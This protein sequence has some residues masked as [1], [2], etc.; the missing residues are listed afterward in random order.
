MSREIKRVPLDFDWPLGEVWG[1]FV[2]PH[3]DG[4]ERCEFCGGS[5]SSS[6][7]LK[8]RNMWYY[9]NELGLP[10]GDWQEKALRVNLT[11][12]DVNFLVDE[13]GLCDLAKQY[14]K[15]EGWVPILNEDGTQY[16]PDAEKVSTIA[17]EHALILMGTDEWILLTHWLEKAGEPLL[18]AACA[19]E[20]RYFPTRKAQKRYEAWTET[21][22][23][24]GDGWQVWEGVSEGSPV[25]PVFE[26]PE[27]L[28]DYLA[29]GGDAWCRRRPDEK[30]PSRRAAIAFVM[31]SGWVPSGAAIPQDDGTVEIRANIHLADR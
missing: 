30:P 22:I 25:S 27:E 24:K 17:R 29:E 6:A 20:G 1:G 13:G 10:V 18:C 23:P 7:L 3:T 14:V 15:G 5:G 11:Q 9:G 16:Y 4:L 12:E 8:L 19:G 28:I 31:S 2:N 21:P 26:T